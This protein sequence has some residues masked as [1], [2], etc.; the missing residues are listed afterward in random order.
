MTAARRPSVREPQPRG[1]LGEV[2]VAGGV[3]PVERCGEG[4]VVVALHG[5]AL[6]RRVWYPLADALAGRVALLLPDRRGFGGAT[7]PPDLAAEIDDVRR[8]A[9]AFGARRFALI[10]LSQGGRVALACAAERIEG[11]VGVAAIGAPVDDVPRS[12]TER[13]VADA[14]LASLRGLRKAGAEAAMRGIILRHP[15]MALARATDSSVR[16]A[17][18]ADYAGRDLFD[19]RPALPLRI[20]DLRRIAVPALAISGA[21]EPDWRRRVA[22][23]IARAAPSARHVSIPGAGH[24]SPLDAPA[25]TAAAILPFLDECF[26]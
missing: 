4:P 22:D 1:A 10:G 2:A 6:D 19:T 8:V 12:P 20:A 23:T 13:V 9:A 3:L 14:P 11:L 21:D 18:I 15:L 5:W 7:A 17:I 24:L 26:R 16:D 25:E